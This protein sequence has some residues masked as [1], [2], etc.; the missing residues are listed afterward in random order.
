MFANYESA[1]GELPL[2]VVL[3]DSDILIEFAGS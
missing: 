2:E 1:C 3:I